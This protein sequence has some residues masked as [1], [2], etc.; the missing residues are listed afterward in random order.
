MT[1]CK[2]V[3]DCVYLLYQKYH[4]INPNQG[5]SYINSPNQIKNKNTTINHI[6]DDDKYFQY[7]P[8][9]A[10]NNKEIGRNY[11]RLSKIKYL[12]SKKL[13]KNTFSTRKDDWKTTPIFAL[14]KLYVKKMNIYPVYISKQKSKPEKQVI[15]L[16]IP[17]EEG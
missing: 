6:N 8:T 10:L 16:M 5:G 4:K 17:I 3:F 7:A 2:F 13:E 14:N 11:Q 12:I 9:V 15:F 1:V